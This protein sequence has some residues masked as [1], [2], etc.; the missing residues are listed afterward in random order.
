MPAYTV[1]EEALR[2]FLVPRLELDTYDGLG[3]LAIEMV[4]TRGLYR[5][6]EADLRP[7]EQLIS[8]SAVVS[9]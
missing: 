3:F 6:C 9:R 2:P 5:G 4:E 8:T 7:E 1:P